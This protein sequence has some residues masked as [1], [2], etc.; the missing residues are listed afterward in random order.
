MKTYL[1][2]GVPHSVAMDGWWLSSSPPPPP[3][4]HDRDSHSLGLPLRAGVL[5]GLIALA[6][7]LLW[8]VMPGLSL[9]VFGLVVIAA[10]WGLAGQRGSG[11][12]GLAVLSV[13]PVIERVQALSLGFW[14]TGL[15]LSAAWIALARWPGL[16]AMPRILG[17]APVQMIRD[18]TSLQRQDTGAEARMQVK[19]LFLGWSLPF[20]L[21]LLFLSL[22][23]EANPILA[24]WLRPPD[25]H[26]VSAERVLF[27]LGVGILAWPFLRLTEIG[28]RLAARPAGV[29]RRDRALPAIINAPAIRRSLILF[30]ALFA[31]QTL[32]DIAIFT[33]GAALPD[34]M[35]YA[36]YA[37]RGAYPLLATALLA[38]VFALIARPFARENRAL[39]AALLAWMVQTLLLV[40]SSLIRLDSYISVYGLTHLRLAALVWMW[41]VAIGV[42]L[43]IVQIVL[44]W[45]A[46]WLLRRCVVLGTGTLYLASF[47]SFAA[48]IAQYNL[49]HDVPHDPS[50]LCRL[51]RAALP[52]IRA[53][54]QATGARLCR[55]QT[56]AFVAT[57]DWRE[58]G[59][60]DWRTARSLQAIETEA[61]EWRGY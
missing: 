35:S 36:E 21:G 24:S 46:A 7:L 30:N 48:I 45:S 56:P 51:D 42:L 9:A 20:G 15:A 60:R 23:V 17:Q 57:G 16:A 53:H 19:S 1:L 39:H 14:F 44:N 12:L 33:G 29:A 4:P 3:R 10:A 32:S 22:L 54:E 58:W 11:A 40:I 6:D 27:W 5:I 43:V 37:H 38:G 13:L 61:Q 18:V 59:F 2:R 31:V 8:K 34:G 55:S 26:L 49:S 28:A 52:A 25:L 41:V 50:Y 47:T